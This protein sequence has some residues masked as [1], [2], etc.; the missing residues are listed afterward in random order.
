MR[1][2]RL[3]KGKVIPY[4]QFVVAYH[5]RTY[6]LEGNQDVIMEMISEEELPKFKKRL[7]SVLKSI[8]DDVI[9][10]INTRMPVIE[11]LLSLK[12][13]RKITMDSEYKDGDL[14]FSYNGQEFDRLSE[15]TV[16]ILG[17]QDKEC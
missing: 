5:L 10:S 16:R 8:D 2:C 11:G 13:G 9:L 6:L 14:V 12:Y 4:I 7:Q 15:K 3:K 17:W 1:Y